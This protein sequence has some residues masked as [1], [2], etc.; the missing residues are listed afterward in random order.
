MSDK[1]GWVGQQCRKENDLCLSHELSLFLLY[2]LPLGSRERQWDDKKRRDGQVFHLT[3]FFS[4]PLHSL[5]LDLALFVRFYLIIARA[6]G[7]NSRSMKYIFKGWN[8]KQVVEERSQPVRRFSVCKRRRAMSMD[9]RIKGW[10]MTFVE[11][12]SSSLGD[13]FI[14]CREYFS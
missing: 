3:S 4:R 14:K 7:S 9:E 6:E 11:K 8:N 2:L 5:R 12:E 1:G 10:L 13:I